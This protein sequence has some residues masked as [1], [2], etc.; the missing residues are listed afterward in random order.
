MNL[1]TSKLSQAVPCYS[2]L[3]FRLRAGHGT[4]PGSQLTCGLSSLQVARRRILQ[5]GDGN[6]LGTI[7]ILEIDNQVEAILQ[8]FDSLESY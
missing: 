1:L 7:A 5:I 8:R 2:K 3:R 6:G 4:E